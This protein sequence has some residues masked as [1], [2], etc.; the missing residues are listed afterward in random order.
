M[1]TDCNLTI[2]DLQTPAF[3]ERVTSGVR[4]LLFVPRGDI[5][6]INAVIA[7]Q[8]EGFEDYVT[9]GSSAMVQKAVTLHS[10]CEFAEI[11]ASRGLGELKYTVQGSAAGNRST[12]ATIE[13]HHPGFRRR[14]L[15]FLAIAANME[16]V[17]LVQLEN[18][19]WHLLGDTDRGATIA[20]SAE[21]TSGKAM[22]D[23]NGATLVFEYDCPM[24]RIMFD[25]WQPENETYGVEMYRMAYLLAD[26]NDYVLTDENDVPIEI[27]VL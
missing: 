14:V 25:D 22:T 27:P 13:I 26:E 19:L 11:Y 6:A 23:Q 2:S 3:C 21:A 18:G 10:G 5:E 8:P 4:R 24:P 20:D 15:A 9:V 16:F 17:L 7:S 12:H 1:Q